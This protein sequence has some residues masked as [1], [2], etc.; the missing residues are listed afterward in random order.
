M[1]S[2][3]KQFGDEAWRREE[4]ESVCSTQ[5]MRGPPLLGREQGA[6]RGIVRR[7]DEGSGSKGQERE[8][9]VLVGRRVRSEPSRHSG[10]D[11]CTHTHDTV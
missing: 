2:T 7:G 5:N 6:H 10:D 11:F 1:N 3:T 9:A 4:D 8:A